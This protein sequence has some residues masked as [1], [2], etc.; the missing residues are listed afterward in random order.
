M[1]RHA[2]VRTGT[3]VKIAFSPEVGAALVDKAEREHRPITEII[4]QAVGELV[5]ARQPDPSR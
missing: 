5:L 3:A 4:R 2:G 1:A